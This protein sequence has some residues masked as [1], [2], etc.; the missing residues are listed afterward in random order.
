MC[1]RCV[2]HDRS[3][4]GFDGTPPPHFTMLRWTCRLRDALERRG[5]Q[6]D[7]YAL[8]RIAEMREAE[9]VSM[10]GVFPSD[11]RW[12]TLVSRV[13]N[14]QN[15]PGLRVYSG[16]G[17]QMWGGRPRLT[18]RDIDPHCPVSMLVRSFSGQPVEDSQQHKIDVLWLS[19]SVFISCFQITDVINGPGPMYRYLFNY[20]ASFSY[21]AGM[22]RQTFFASSLSIVE[23]DG[24]R[25]PSPLSLAF[26]QHV[27][28][29]LPA[30]YFNEISLRR[31]IPQICPVDYLILFLS[32]IPHNRAPTTQKKADSPVRV[33]L[34]GE[35]TITRD[36]FHQILSHQFHPV[37]QLSFDYSPFD[38]SVSHTAFNDLLRDALYL[39][40]VKLPRGLVRTDSGRDG[41]LGD[42]V[43]IDLKTPDL[44]IQCSCSAK[45]PKWLHATA[46]H[47]NAKD[48]NLTFSRQS[49][50]WTRAQRL[51]FLQPFVNLFMDSDSSLENV[52]LIFDCHIF[53]SEGVQDE[54]QACNGNPEQKR[55][56]K[57]N[58]VALMVASEI[59]ACNSRNLCVFNSYIGD[60]TS[61]RID[62]RCNH[63]EWWDKAIIPV[64]V[65]N[66]HRKRLTNPVGAVIQLALRAVNQG[67][68]YRKTTDHLP[69]DA[70]IANAGLIF[71]IVKQQAQGHAGF[72]YSRRSRGD[73]RKRHE[74]GYF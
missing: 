37:V 50:S 24:R 57:I 14:R 9:L 59:P 1:H 72:D 54:E 3:F 47:H 62:W 5:F 74:E 29:L 7:R 32:I 46:K 38:E 17:F 69:C 12:E 49:G 31:R 21:N 13:R 18:F 65:L 40:A 71:C 26:F 8:P 41:R 44:W 15:I 25:E 23:G 30:D 68:V 66:F 27:T 34:H 55:T 53:A 67:V 16:G 51:E 52:C 28:A 64:L 19:A 35:R 39:R 73:K 70:S 36:E 43:K 6:V 22:T 45:S 20:E 58:Q 48:I 42:F 11:F 63:V 60:G 61:K 4:S 33:V 56:K 10:N 2:L